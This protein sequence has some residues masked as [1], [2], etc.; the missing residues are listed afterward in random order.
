MSIVVWAAVTIA[1]LLIFKSCNA[2]EGFSTLKE[3]NPLL[4]HGT[5]EL[6]GYTG[7]H[8]SWLDDMDQYNQNIR[9]NKEDTKPLSDIQKY[10]EIESKYGH[11]RSKSNYSAVV[12]SPFVS[13]GMASKG[14]GN[15][16][17][18]FINAKDK[19]IP[20]KYN[21]YTIYHNMLTPTRGTGNNKQ[22]I[23]T[24]LDNCLA[25]CDNDPRCNHVSWSGTNHRTSSKSQGTCMLHNAGETPELVYGITTFTK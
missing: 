7:P 4:Q 10:L 22:W 2:Q 3:I 11:T 13:E 5:S 12:G 6:K 23:R 15:L 14:H 24:N 19:D 25:H 17:R 18:T 20:K 8:H 21:G 1:L 9:Y 16:L